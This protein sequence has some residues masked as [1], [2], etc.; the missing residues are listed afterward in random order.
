MRIEAHIGSYTIPGTG[1]LVDAD[2]RLVLTASHVVSGS[3]SFN[4]RYGQREINARLHANAPCD[5]LAMLQLVNKPTGLSELPIL[6]SDDLKPGDRVLAAGFGDARKSEKPQSRYG[7]VTAANIPTQANKSLPPLPSAVEHNAV[8]KGGDSGGPLLDMRGRVVGIN[9]TVVRSRASGDPG[10][11]HYYAMSASR[12]N[13]LLPGLVDGESRADVGWKLRAD[14]RAKIRKVL[15]LDIGRFY[16]AA[17]VVAGVTPGSPADK[18]GLSIGDAIVEMRGVD[19]TESV[20]D[21]CRILADSAGSSISVHAG[22]TARPKGWTT[23]L[24]VP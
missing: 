3:S 1:I 23:R 20:R 17:V 10:R 14:T 5:D 6:A 16:D 12:V 21:V 22:S 15:G 9:N 2:R 19:R 11:D 8:V 18:A 7:T 13:E 4:V 24:R